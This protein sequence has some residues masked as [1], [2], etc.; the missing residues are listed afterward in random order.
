[1]K[2]INNLHIIHICSI[3]INIIILRK[4]NVKMAVQNFYPITNF[5]IIS[6]L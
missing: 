2:K 6:N 5:K 1:M 4:S 3:L